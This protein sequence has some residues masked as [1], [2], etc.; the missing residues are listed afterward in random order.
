MADALIS[1]LSGG[2]EIV[3]RPLSAIRRYNSVEQDAL[4]AGRE[5]A[6]ESIL[7][8]PIQT[9][10]ERIRV[11]AK[12]LRTSDGKQLWTGQFDEKFDDIFA[13]QDSIS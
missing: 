9:W 6:V 4:A 11:S 13:G 7:D 12:L 1:K 3:V 8:G 10:G 2:A 5:L